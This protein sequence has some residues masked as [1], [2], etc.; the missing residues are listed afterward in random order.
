MRRFR[1]W[2]GELAVELQGDSGPTVVL[3]HAFPLTHA[4]WR[5]QLAHL[6]GR[7][8]VIAPDLL[9][10]GESIASKPAAPV[11]MSELSAGVI[12]VLVALHVRSCVVVGLSMGGYVALSMAAKIPHLMGGLVLSDTRAEA[13]SAEAAANRERQAQRAL[14]AGVPALAGELCAKLCGKT[15]HAERPEVVSEVRGLVEACP[16]EAFAAAQRG[17]AVRRDARQLLPM[18]KMP[19][20]VIVGDEDTLTGPDAA[21]TLAEGLPKAEL[22]VLPGAGHLSN[23]EAPTAWNAALDALLARA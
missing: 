14:A 20:A 9:G 5:P 8:Q 4:M 16:P 6:R 2:G 3:L 13:D 18:L 15:T 7:A 1:V 10:F 17:M 23:L 19:A 12:E 21:R 22:H 11:S